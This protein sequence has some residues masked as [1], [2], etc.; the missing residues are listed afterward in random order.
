VSDCTG[1]A[2]AAIRNVLAEF[3]ADFDR[4]QREIEDLLDD[5]SARLTAEHAPGDSASPAEQAELPVALLSR[6]LLQE[7]QARQQQQAEIQGELR[8]LRSLIE[9][10][11]ASFQP[12][13]RDVDPAGVA[14]EPAGGSRDWGGG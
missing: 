6:S 4:W 5:V 9:R 1:P 7:R 13:R 10:Q 2:L 14:E 11:I 12:R 3:H 8:A